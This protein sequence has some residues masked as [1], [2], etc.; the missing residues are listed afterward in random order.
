[1]DTKLAD[2][3]LLSAA[4]TADDCWAELHVCDK[5]PLERLDCKIPN[6]IQYKNVMGAFL[7]NSITVSYNA[8]LHFILYK[9]IIKLGMEYIKRKMQTGLHF[10]R[11][12]AT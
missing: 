7:K 11:W 2:T 8:P 3:V 9:T 6:V 10:H 4:A 5:T 12:A 1:M